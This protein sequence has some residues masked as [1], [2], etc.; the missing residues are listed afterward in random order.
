MVQYI[1]DGNIQK[2]NLGLREYHFSSTSENI[3]FIVKNLLTEFE[4]SF[5][6]VISITTDNA[7]NYIG[8]VDL[9]QDKNDESYDVE[10]YQLDEVENFDFYDNLK[11]V[12]LPRLI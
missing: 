10:E 9:M 6:N 1:E 12:A 3:K 5:D 4:L 11:E 7:A 2:I 8:A